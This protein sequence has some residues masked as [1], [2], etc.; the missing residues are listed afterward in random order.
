MAGLTG[1]IDRKMKGKEFLKVSN[2]N[3][4]TATTIYQ[5]ALVSINAGGEAVNATG[6]LQ[7]VGIARKTIENPGAATITRSFVVD[8]NYEI[9]VAIAAATEADLFED[10]FVS[11]N[12]LV[13]L[14]PS[15]SLKAKVGKIV[16]VISST[17]VRVDM[18]YSWMTGDN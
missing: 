17:K 5:G 2:L 3:V 7:F 15:A 6:S 4:A 14:T 13:T 10:V 16:E 8:R 9:E 1:P 12:N 18:G 11:D